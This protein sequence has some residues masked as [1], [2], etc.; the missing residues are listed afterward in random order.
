MI[1]I[2]F[3]SNAFSIFSSELLSYLGSVVTSCLRGGGDLAGVL[4]TAGS[5]SVTTSISPPLHPLPASPSTADR[6]L[7]V[8]LPCC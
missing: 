4:A 3:L 7:G 2:W 1:L 8:K 6:S 5:S